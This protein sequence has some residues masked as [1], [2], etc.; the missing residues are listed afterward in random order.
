MLETLNL[1]AKLPK[2]EYREAQDALDLTLARLQRL[3]REVNVPAIA[4]FEGWDAA[5]KGAVLS[6]LLQPLDPRYFKVHNMRAPTSLERMFAPLRRFW[7]RLPAHGVIGIFNHSWYLEVLEQRVEEDWDAARCADAY[8]RIRVFERQLVDDGAVLLKFF[9]HISEEEQ[10][11]RFKK[12]EQD[13]AFAWK[14]GKDERRRHKAYAAYRDAAEDML[15][16]TSVPFAPWTALPATSE[17]FAK[18][19]VAETMAAALEQAVARDGADAAHQPLP[20]PQARPPRRTSPLELIDEDQSL[21]RDEYAKRLP[22]LQLELRRLQHICYKRRVPV[23]IVYEGQDASGKGGNI[24]RLVREMDP[25]GYEVI[26]I[27]APSGEEKRHHYLWRFWRA[28]PK[29][30]HFTIF[31]RSWYGRVLVERVE[32]FATEQEWQRAYREI[33]EFENQLHEAG[34]VIIKFWIQIS[35]DEQLAR[36]RS[37]EETPHKRWKINDED[38]RNREKWEDYEEAVADM[39]ERTST[40]NAPWTILEGDNKRHARIKA[41]RVVI[42]SLE[43]ALETG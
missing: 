4:V 21:S 2:S 12:L 30:G 27:A 35:K 26:P 38:W 42:A 9:L 28:T 11:R 6:R 22:K 18:V 29:A 15:R 20:L 1:D 40:L 14:V 36:F 23:V 17:R 5:G 10:A 13:S 24:R 19:K 33:N 37:R 43:T 39:I 34:A 32:G 41:L 25:R 31:D 3:L 16:E 8:E 7:V